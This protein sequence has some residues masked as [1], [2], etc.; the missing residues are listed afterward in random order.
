MNMSQE[1]SKKRNGGS[2]EAEG[3]ESKTEMMVRCKVARRVRRLK[4]V[5][6]PTENARNDKEPKKE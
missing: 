2:P 6:K 5:E 1:R 4:N 3:K